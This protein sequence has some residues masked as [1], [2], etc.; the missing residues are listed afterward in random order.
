MKPINNLA[1]AKRANVEAGRHW[2]DDETL[3]AFGSSFEE[4]W[5]KNYREQRTYFV[6]RLTDPD[7]IKGIKAVYAKTGRSRQ[8][9]GPLRI[10]PELL[11]FDGT[12]VM[13]RVCSIDWHTA[14]VQTLDSY[15][16]PT[17][18]GRRALDLAQWEKGSEA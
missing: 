1:E 13:Y 11:T 5:A 4:T 7:T 18:A 12:E 16:N 10:G 15:D 6:E 3:E 2:F 9:C 14:H 17:S 8:I